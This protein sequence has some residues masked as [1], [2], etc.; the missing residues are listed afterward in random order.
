MV[1]QRLHPMSTREWEAA[2]DAADLIIGPSFGFQA[3]SGEWNAAV[4][5]ATGDSLTVAARDELIE[6]LRKAVAATVNRVLCATPVRQSYR[7]QP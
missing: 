4:H 7:S 1:E 3:A 2:I 5:V 6:E